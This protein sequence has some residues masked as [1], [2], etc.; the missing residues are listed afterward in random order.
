MRGSTV[1]ARGHH[2]RFA[3]NPGAMQNDAA[4]VLWALTG[5][6]TYR[7]FVVER[8]WSAARYRAWLGTT[9]ERLLFAE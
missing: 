9:L 2:G 7:V 3:A 5:P 4:D 1:F 8:G 6:D